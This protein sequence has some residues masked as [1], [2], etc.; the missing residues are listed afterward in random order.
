MGGEDQQ[1]RNGVGHSTYKILPGKTGHKYRFSIRPLNSGK[2]S[3]KK[4]NNE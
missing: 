1:K 3:G 4:R 2:G